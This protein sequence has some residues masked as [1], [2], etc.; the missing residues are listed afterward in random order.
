[1]KGRMLSVIQ[2]SNRTGSTKPSWMAQDMVLLLVD[3][4]G[5]CFVLFWQFNLSNAGMPTC[6][7]P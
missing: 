6:A 3:A 4:C 7:P 5:N 2:Q 1:M